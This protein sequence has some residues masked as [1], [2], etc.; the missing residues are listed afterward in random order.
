[1][2]VLLIEDERPLALAVIQML[3]RAGLNVS[4]QR[5]GS[6]G[7]EAAKSGS[8]DVIVLDV[9]LPGKNGLDICRDLREARINTRILMLS[10]LDEVDDRVKG[11][12]LGADDYLAKPFDVTELVARV[13]A[14]LRRD[15]SNKA[16]TI[17]IGDLVVDREAKRA[18]RL[19]TDL[20][21]V[22]SEYAL[23]ETLAV[24]EGEV[25]HH[26]VL[27]EVAAFSPDPLSDPVEAGI[28][29]LRRKIDL[30][31]TSALIQARDGG[32]AIL[33]AA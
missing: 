6:Q 14:L 3:T 22:P 19:G 7:F 31:F 28:A 29:A 21:L 2:N 25:V 9:M 26:D 32:Y 11:L 30:P 13:N 23:L 1:M 15:V 8:Y 27:A 4:W 5:D 10:A 16:N 12:N 17:R 33:A 24:H 20:N 18:R